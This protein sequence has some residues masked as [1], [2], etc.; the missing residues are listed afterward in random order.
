MTNLTLFA[1]EML[2]LLAATGFFICLKLLSSPKTA[3]LGNLI[4]A[5]GMLLAVIVTFIMYKP[6]NLVPIFAMIILGSVFGV[7]SAKKVHMTAMPQM[8]AI[9]NGF[10]GLA[11]V[12]VTLSE[13]LRFSHQQE[14]ASALFS[15]SSWFSIA[16]GAI[17]FTGSV[18]AFL[19][20]QEL[21]PTR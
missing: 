8:V 17:T 19:K 18:I 5:L 3:R 7:V 10:G 15:I 1:Y 12:L 20:L 16:V 6:D 2:F 13:V 14:Q 11:S 4:G 21:M 9:F